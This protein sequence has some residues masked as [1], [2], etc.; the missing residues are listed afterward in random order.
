MSDAKKAIAEGSTFLGIEFGSTRIKAVLTDKEYNSLA[1][2]SF[3]WENKLVDGIWTY[4]L[5][6]IQEGVRA[7]YKDLKEDVKNKYGEDLT[8]VG[9]MGVSAM[10]HGY[11]PF[12][13]DG[14]LLVPFRTW[15]NT[16]TEEA[17]DKLTEALG[18]HIPQ[19]WSIAHFYQ[20]IL[21][22]EEHVGKIAFFTTL[23]GYIHLLLTGEKVLGIGDA[24]GMFPIDSATCDYNAGMLDTFDS[25]AEVKSAGIKIRD[26]LPKVL[27]AGER[28]GVLTKEGA[29][30]L[31]PEGT[32]KEGVPVCP[33]EGDAGTGMVAT[34]S[35][36][37][38][39]GNISAGTS[40]FSMVV[41]EHD[42]SKAYPE[43]DIV[44]TPS[45]EQVAMV[46]CNNCTSDLNAWVSLFREFAK[47]IGH[48]I[49]DDE[50]YGGLYR[51]AM[52]GDSD[53]GGLLAYNYFS[54]ESITGFNEGRPLFV[55]RPDD[56]FNLSNFMRTHLYT[57]LGALKLGNDILIKEEKVNVDFFF[58]Q[59]GF[60][61]IRGAGDKVMAA[62]LGTTIK[63]M[64]TAGEG[65]PWGQAILAGYMMQKQDGESLEKYLNDK[66]FTN[67][68][69]ETCEPE[70]K[71]VKG[72][73]EFIKDY[74]AGLAV[75]KAAVESLR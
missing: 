12:D 3:S 23:A 20:A 67:V 63:L 47:L 49:S 26:I 30:F 54:G 40:V 4:G 8:T 9:A 53:C 71:D 7:C 21:N 59:G 74:S 10:M 34:N 2:G 75:E 48:D 50:L 29:L 39:T 15:R 16:I 73:D 1:S 44:T 61:K 65:G 57:A 14:N 28:A 66:V 64:E 24:S 38:R 25:L 60:F 62:A 17:S 35:V 55:R 6:Y 56:V 22:K 69:V 70:E 46:H 45:G 42:L 19:R 58:G 41:L 27:C 11:M 13:K 33:P 52:E 36:A 31:D 43:L 37:K 5:D 51:K 68:S 72:F 32:L 18:F